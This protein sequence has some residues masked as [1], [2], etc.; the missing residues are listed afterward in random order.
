MP[1]EIASV[2]F[3]LLTGVKVCSKSILLWVQA[4]GHL[5]MEQSNTQLAAPGQG[6]LPAE[7]VTEAANKVLPLLVGWGWT[8]EMKATMGEIEE[9]RVALPP[10]KTSLGGN[11]VD[12]HS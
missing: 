1:F 9:W 7:E 6:G 10:A 4:S 11:Q 12:C 5:A 2:L 3:G 8:I